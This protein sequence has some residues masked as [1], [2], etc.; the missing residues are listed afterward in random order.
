MSNTTLRVIVSLIAAPLIV[1]LTLLGSWWFAAFALALAVLALR[2]YYNLA[3]HTDA[4]PLAAM[5]YIGT[6]AIASSFFLGGLANPRLQSILFPSI[7]LILTLAILI[8][9]LLRNKA[10]PLRNS[11]ITGFGVMYVGTFL[12]SLIGLREMFSADALSLSVFE[13]IVVA[14]RAAVGDRWGAWLVFATFIGIWTCD[15]MAFFAGKAFG[16][17]KLFERVSPNKSWEGAV[18]GFLSSSAAFVALAYYLLPFLP[19]LHAGI[20]GGLVGI[21]GPFGDLVESLFKRDA[22]VKDSSNIIPGHG[23]VYDRF[24]AAMFVAPVV[25]VY[26]KIFLALS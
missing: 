11:A 20:I 16:K 7:F 5:G 26:V 1:G 2:E 17:H 3:L 19:L 10:H 24:D 25:Y 4:M 8:V 21:I 22:G 13:N 18:V 9:E 15:S 12:A 14:E 6:V 23:G